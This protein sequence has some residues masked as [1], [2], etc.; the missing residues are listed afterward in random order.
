MTTDTIENVNE[1]ILKVKSLISVS[2]GETK[3]GWESFAK[4]C[5]SFVKASK[6]QLKDK[7]SALRFSAEQASGVHS[8]LNSKDSDNVKIGKEILFKN[9]SFLGGYLL[10]VA[11]NLKEESTNKRTKGDLLY[12]AFSD[13]S[14]IAKIT[15]MYAKYFLQGFKFSVSIHRF[16]MGQSIDISYSTEIEGNRA[17]ARNL[18]RFLNRFND[19]RYNDYS[20]TDYNFYTSICKM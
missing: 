11:K 19:I 8:L 16:S 13:I 1:L 4:E 17:A 5:K 15:R 12:S 7:Y 3:E 20:S 6:K 18:E 2:F 14:D 9:K 10:W